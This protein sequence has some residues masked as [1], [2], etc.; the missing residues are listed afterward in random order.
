MSDTYLEV[1]LPDRDEA[2]EICRWPNRKSYV[3]SARLGNLSVP[4][5][6]FRSEGA[7][8][9]AIELLRDIAGVR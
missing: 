6:Y 4:L 8:R 5:A 7:A 2:L 3:L 1:T 9:K